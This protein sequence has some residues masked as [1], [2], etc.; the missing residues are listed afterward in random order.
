MNRTYIVGAIVVVVLLSGLIAL[1]SLLVAP[2]A[3]PEQAIETQ[4][5]APPPPTP[6]PP[7]R[8]TIGERVRAQGVAITV[9]GIEWSPSPEGTRPGE[10]RVLLVHMLVENTNPT[11]ELAVSSGDMAVRLPNGQVLDSFPENVVDDQLGDISLASNEEQT[12]TVVFELAR[13]EET[14][15]LLYDYND[16]HIDIDLS[17]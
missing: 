14:L 15:H 9:T 13:T 2:V 7:V 4:P 3:P 8:G 12:V 16:Q 1:G 17:Q 10:S 6:A 5:A 11:F